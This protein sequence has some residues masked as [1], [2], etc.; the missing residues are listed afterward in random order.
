MTPGDPKSARSA[1]HVWNLDAG[2]PPVAI[3]CDGFVHSPFSPDGSR[4]VVRRRDGDAFLSVVCDTGT[5]KD[6]ASWAHVNNQLRTYSPDGVRLAFV[7]AE[8]APNG[9]PV[10]AVTLRIWDV[11]AGQDLHSF[12]LPLGSDG[13]TW[14]EFSRSSG[15]SFSRDGSRLVVKGAAAS[16]NIFL[17][18]FDPIAGKRLCMVTTPGPQD[19]GIGRGNPSP[20]FSPDGKQL[21]VASGNVITTWDVITGRPLRTLRG[22][23]RP[24]VAYS[25]SATGRLWSLE[26]DG[27]L[28]EW[29]TS[30]TAPVV[31]PLAPGRDTRQVVV[32][33]DGR[34][35][36]TAA[37]L[38]GRIGPLPEVTPDIQ[39]WDVAGHRATPLTARPK[40]FACTRALAIE[41]RRPAARP[42]PSTRCRIA[43]R[44]RTRVKGA[45]SPAT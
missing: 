10:T 45:P 39:V 30:P 14:S 37:S 34:W 33:A 15:L 28:K 25:F 44:A 5:G 26:S 18:V 20:I 17:L 43:Q 41:R 21:A 16:G 3:P 29:D 40:E 1:V 2:G 35:L 4:I 7:V 36:A 19:Q 23:K 11:V 42:P 32:S 12:P 31:L 6:V 9:G 8:P 24:P 27:T 38:T 22:H 13:F